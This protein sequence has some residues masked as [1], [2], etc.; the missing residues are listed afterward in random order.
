VRLGGIARLYMPCL[1]HSQIGLKDLG[2]ADGAVAEVQVEYPLYTDAGAYEEGGRARFMWE[3]NSA[4][5]QRR[6]AWLRG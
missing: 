2:N 4:D 1:G 3:G 6:L 5:S